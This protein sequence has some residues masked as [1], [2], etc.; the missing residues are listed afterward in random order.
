M[1]EW[2]NKLTLPFIIYPEGFQ[3]IWIKDHSWY[4]RGMILTSTLLANFTFLSIRS[5]PSGVVYVYD[6]RIYQ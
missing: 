1:N 6:E 4:Y 3:I 5:M 2:V